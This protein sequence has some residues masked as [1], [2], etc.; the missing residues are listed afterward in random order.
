[1]TTL[2]IGPKEELRARARDTPPRH[3][4][5]DGPEVHPKRTALSALADGERWRGLGDRAR[6]MDLVANPPASLAVLVA[7]TQRGGWAPGEQHP[8]LEWAG[9]LYG[10]L[11]AIPV[12]VALYG[13]A[14]LLQ[15]PGRLAL[16]VTIG[17]LLALT[18]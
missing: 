15:R 6:Q 18:T 4:G 9:W 3:G 14:W 11:V 12:T 7:H 8:V 16:L 5:G 17:A 10:W 2:D 1:M 13:A